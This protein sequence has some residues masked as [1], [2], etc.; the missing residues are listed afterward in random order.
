[1]KYPIEPLPGE[2]VQIRPWRSPDDLRCVQEATSDPEIP[3]GTTV[4]AVFTEASGLAFL[5]RRPSPGSRKDGCATSSGLHGGTTD[6][7]VFA[8]VPPE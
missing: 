5:D 1:M 4:P 7:L 6:G 8:R 3:A 2:L